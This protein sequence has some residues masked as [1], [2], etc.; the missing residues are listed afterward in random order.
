MAASLTTRLDS[1]SR[2]PELTLAMV[3]GGRLQLPADWAG[4]AGALLFYR[5]HW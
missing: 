1:G 3:G 4:H 5:G 2:F